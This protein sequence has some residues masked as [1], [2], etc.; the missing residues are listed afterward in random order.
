VPDAALRDK[1]DIALRDKIVR[2]HAN[3]AL[4]REDAA[5]RI[6]AY[7]YG[8]ILVLAAM[9]ALDVTD[10][11][12]GHAVVIELGVA[13]ST[14]LAHVF[15]EVIGRNVRSGAPTTMTDVLHELRDSTP[16]L[17]SA[18]IPCLLLTAGALAWL[19]ESTAITASEIYL[20]AR[21]A[22]VGLVVERF[23]SRRASPRTLLAGVLMAVIAAGIALL[24]V[25]LSY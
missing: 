11:H 5:A 17:T 21:L 18:L 14:F 19:S 1:P 20:F 9:L 6:S 7:V 12:H 2:F 22:L 15:S 23:G 25:T 13:F 8:N 4:P 10:V 16:I 24:K 3:P